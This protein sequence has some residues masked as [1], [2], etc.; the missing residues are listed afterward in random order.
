MWCYPKVTS[1]KP[2]N[3]QTII[4]ITFTVTQSTPRAQVFLGYFLEPIPFISK[5]FFQIGVF[6]KLQQSDRV[7]LTLQNEQSSMVSTSTRL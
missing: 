5:Y 3:L 4:T 7:M 6:L 1:L 2:E